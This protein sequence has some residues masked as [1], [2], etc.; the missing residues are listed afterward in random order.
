MKKKILIVSGIVILAIV[1]G[2]LYYTFRKSPD[3]VKNM[4]PDYIVDASVLVDEFMEDEN[5]TN[6]KYLDKIIQVEGNIVEIEEAQDENTLVYLEGNLMGNISC[7]FNNGELDKEKIAIGKTV[8]VKGK[9][10]GFILDVVLTKC[11][12]VE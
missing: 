8:T 6:Q 9:C 3:S 5:A 7:Q 12:L 1:A 2:A 4:K 10:T 11:A